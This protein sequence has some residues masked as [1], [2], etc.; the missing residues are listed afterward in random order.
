MQLGVIHVTPFNS[1]EVL[2]DTASL[3]PITV[4]INVNV[5]LSYTTH[6]YTKH[7]EI[8]PLTLFL[9]MHPLYNPPS[10][11]QDRDG[12]RRRER[13]LLLTYGK[14]ESHRQ[15]YNQKVVLS[16]FLLMKA[17][18][19]AAISPPVW[20]TLEWDTTGATVHVTLYIWVCVTV[21]RLWGLREGMVVYVSFFGI[22]FVCKWC[23][24]ELELHRYARLAVAMQH[25]ETNTFLS[26]ASHLHT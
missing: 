24:L 8:W 12:W 17:K 7:P 26:I 18:S 5:M 25:A 9:E 11:S 1:N 6:T 3:Y 16:F 23:A 10:R 20:N 19:F 2:S 13:E 22:L 21:W 15:Y 14:R 4:I